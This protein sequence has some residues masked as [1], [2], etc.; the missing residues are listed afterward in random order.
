MEQAPAPGFHKYRDESSS[1]PFMAR[2]FVGLYDLR[3]QLLLLGNPADKDVL[4]ARFDKAVMPLIL[5]AE[6]TR[7]AAV[8]IVRLTSD[9]LSAVASGSVVR[10]TGKH[11]SIDATID[12]PLGQTLYKLLN[13]SIIAT[14]T[15]LQDVL[16]DPLGLDIGFLFQQDRGFT[17]GVAKLRAA[18]DPALADYLEAIR[19]WHGDLQ[20]LRD[21]HEHDGWVLGQIRYGRAPPDVEVHLPAVFGVSVDVFARAAA[22]RLLLFI[23]NTVVY[24]MRRCNKTE[25]P[26]VVMEIPPEQRDPKLPRRFRVVVGRTIRPWKP[27]FV[28]SADFV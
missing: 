16:K 19:R 15:C 13:Q 2:I 14:K 21:A 25:F 4:R 17:S 5:A 7:D 26:I 6:A 23:E 1:S 20:K 22:N 8:E 10:I 27:E 9:H 28:D 18:G 12:A 11:F 24:A 3:D